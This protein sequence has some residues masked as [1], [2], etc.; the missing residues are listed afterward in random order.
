LKAMKEQK[1]KEAFQIVERIIAQ[2]REEYRV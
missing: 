1:G 2:I